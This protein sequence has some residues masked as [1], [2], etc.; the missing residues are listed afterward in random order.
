MTDAGLDALPVVLT[1]EEAARLLRLS[2][3]TAYELAA[4]Y[5]ATEGKEG[6]P[7]VRLGRR[8]RVPRHRLE[9]MLEGSSE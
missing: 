9:Q 6:L 7:V 1:V 4:R 8:L 5:L 3:S 2:R